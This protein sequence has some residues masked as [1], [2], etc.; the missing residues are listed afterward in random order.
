MFVLVDDFFR[1]S[2]VILLKNK[3]DVGS[4]LK[5]WKTLVEN[6]Y[7]EKMVPNRQW[8]GV[9]QCRTVDM[10]KGEGGQA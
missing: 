3:N 7:R 6:K 10:V 5:E 8:R 4:R 2:W 9:L 1:K